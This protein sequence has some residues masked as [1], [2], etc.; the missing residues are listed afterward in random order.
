MSIRNRL[1]VTLMTL[2]CFSIAA[3]VLT[4]LWHDEA[5]GMDREDLRYRSESILDQDSSQTTKHYPEAKLN[6]W[7]DDAVR[8]IAEISLS[9]ERETTLVIVI[10]KTLYTM[11]SDYIQILGLVYFYK[12]ASLDLDRSPRGSRRTTPSG[13]GKDVSYTDGPPIVHMDLG[14]E[15]KKIRIAPVPKHKDSAFVTYAAYPDALSDDTTE[16]ELST[17][18]ELVVPDYVAWQ[19]TMKL[20]LDRN[21]FQ[22]SFE[23]KLRALGIPFMRRP[24]E[25]AT[26]AETPSAP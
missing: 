3:L 25:P 13:M 16:C 7:I 15:I 18:Y 5:H 22:E 9:F 8:F 20:M 2:W 4:A 24:P 1:L 14:P 11:P 23:A 26:P 21:P 17:A 6:M 10:S 12:G 19:A